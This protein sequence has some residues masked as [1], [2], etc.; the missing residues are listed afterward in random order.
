VEFSVGATNEPLRFQWRV[1]GVNIP[2]ATNAVLA[3]TNV[4]T[5]NG[6]AYSVLVANPVG[7]IL[8]ANVTLTVTD[9]QTPTRDNDYFSQAEDLIGL[10]G[11][12]VGT[13]RC[14]G[15]EPGE[16]AHAGRKGGRSVWF[17]WTAPTNGI[18]TFDTAG[19]AFD[20]VLAVYTGDEV[21]HLTNV[22]SDEDSGPFLT[23]RLQFNADGG[24]NYQIALDGFAGQS[25]DYVLHWSME[26][27]TER[28]PT[29]TA[30]PKSVA[31]TNEGAGAKFVVQ[32]DAIGY[33]WFF[34]RQPI[35]DATNQEYALSGVSSTQLGK[36]HVLVSN[37]HRSIESQ[38]AALEIGLAPSDDKPEE[39]LAPLYGG[40]GPCPGAGFNSRAVGL[41]LAHSPILSVALGSVGLHV[42]N[43][44][45]LLVS[46]DTDCTR[47]PGTGISWLFLQFQCAGK[48]R[49]DARRSGFPVRLRLNDASD[50]P[51]FVTLKCRTNQMQYPVTDFSHGYWIGM[52]A[53]GGQLGL[54]Q[55]DW[56]FDIAPPAFSTNAD[57][58]L[59]LG[60]T[61]SLCWPG[62]NNPAFAF[63]WQR[64][65]TDIPGATDICYVVTHVLKEHAGSYR[66][67][68]SSKSDASTNEMGFVKVESPPEIRE[69][70]H[71]TNLFL[72]GTATFAVSAEGTEPLTYQWQFNGTDIA[73]ATSNQLT[74]ARAQ[75]SDRGRYRVWVANRLG[76][77]N[78]EWCQLKVHAPVVALAPTDAI[79][80]SCLHNTFN[81]T[82]S[83]DEPTNYVW[84]VWPANESPFVTNGS[85]SFVV[86]T[87][88]LCTTRSFVIKVEPQY[89]F[90]I[91]SNQVTAVANLQLTGPSRPE[92][93]WTLME[94]KLRLTLD[95]G[96]CCWTHR[97][98]ACDNLTLAA[99]NPAAWIP[100]LTNLS[101]GDYEVPIPTNWPQSFYRVAYTN[102][103]PP[104]TP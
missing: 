58:G 42:L 26:E 65:G 17:S 104:P 35:A 76:T 84:S 98:E 99:T 51:S 48:L 77:T 53:M 49:L 31:A 57:R 30:H 6:G 10:Q 2:E 7:A 103:P 68:V 19:S 100:L 12:I 50:P 101:E 71:G 78:S 27:T 70:P 83:N 18:A 9:V 62:T 66:V 41:K 89:D 56:A 61:L 85:P 5:T 22:V 55:L 91:Q 97:I 8:S 25:G 79:S 43:N 63:Q 14:N 3:L 34:N 16:P 40:S 73:G 82:W 80:A 24:T 81:T 39:L 75:I 96:R 60:E 44:T 20:T 21:A 15:K 32:T 90:A 29:I 64:D 92:V 95:S 4:Q 47:D 23:S 59:P 69:Q 74:I 94:G 93:R 86:P 102:S 37:T 28:L 52:E 87:S 67:L 72:D 11:S 13:N 36:Y 46:A 45:P 88:L 33:Q 54:I 38:R 1:N